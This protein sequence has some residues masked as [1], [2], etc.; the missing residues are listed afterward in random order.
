MSTYLHQDPD[1]QRQLRDRVISAA[2]EEGSETRDP[3]RL[4][5]V[6]KPRNKAWSKDGVIAVVDPVLGMSQAIKEDSMVTPPRSR[7]RGTISGSEAL[8][9]EEE[10]RS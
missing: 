4:S 8:G 1:V 7:A 9:D 10:R 6:I 2:D 3:R 5:T